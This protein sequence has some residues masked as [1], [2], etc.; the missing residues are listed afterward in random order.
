MDFSTDKL[1]QETTSGPLLVC[2]SIALGLGMFLMKRK[3]INDVKASV[4]I[5]TGCDSGFRFSLALHCAELGMEVVAGCFTMGEGRQVLEKTGQVTVVD[6]HVRNEESVRNAVSL[7]QT[8]RDKR[9]IYCLV[10]NAAVLVF[11]EAT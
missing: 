1:F 3:T 9:G 4:I 7:V 6:L 2:G 8:V 10:N 5:I 11:G